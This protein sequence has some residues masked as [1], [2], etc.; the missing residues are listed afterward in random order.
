MFWSKNQKEKKTKG[1]HLP[2]HVINLIIL[3]NNVALK[4]N[5]AGAQSNT[6]D[7]ETLLKELENLEV[8][9]KNNIANIKYGRRQRLRPVHTPQIPVDQEQIF[10]DEI[11]QLLCTK[12]H[13][14]LGKFGKYNEWKARVLVRVGRELAGVEVVGGD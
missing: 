4:Y 7:A 13:L 8:Q 11:G 2:K 12:Q 1:N 5:I 9:I 10:L 14:L 3:K 6:A